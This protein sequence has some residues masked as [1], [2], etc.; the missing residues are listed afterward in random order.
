M[1]WLF[2]DFNA[3]GN[4]SVLPLEVVA[5]LG[6]VML[7]LKAIGV[8]AVFYF[9]YMIVMIVLNYKRFRKLENVED[10]ICSLEK[11]VDKILKRF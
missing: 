10:Q 1:F 6:Q 3:V 5:E 4:V 2:M 7:F 9:C 8:A 11:K